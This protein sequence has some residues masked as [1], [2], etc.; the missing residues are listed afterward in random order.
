MNTVIRWLLRI[1]PAAIL[2]QTLYFKFTAHPESVALFT[3][4]GVEPWGRIGTG[5]L[6]LICGLLL[7]I[8]ATTRYGALMATGLMIG[9]IGSHLF[10]IGVES[11]DDGGYLFI[12]AIV[13]LVTAVINLYLYRDELKGDLGRMI[14]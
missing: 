6:E 12:L 9:A 4:L 14:G 7:L 2:L 10:V 11:M 5:I 13:V 8:P 3:T 1:I